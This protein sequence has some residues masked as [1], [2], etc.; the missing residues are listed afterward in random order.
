VLGLGYLA[1]RIHWGVG[2]AFTIVAL[3]LLTSI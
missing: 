3:G 1:F 2:A